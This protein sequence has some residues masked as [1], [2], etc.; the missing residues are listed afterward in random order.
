MRQDAVTLERFYDA[1]LGQAVARVLSGKLTD[2][3]GEAR[4]LSMLGVGFAVPVLNA[5]DDAPSRIVAAV[6][7]EHGPVK[8]DFSGRGNATVSVGDERLPFPDGMFDRV[9]V[10]HGL[11]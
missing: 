2:L 6:P 11:E 8:W 4:G 10:L 5:F 3:W 9:I 7:L 1:P